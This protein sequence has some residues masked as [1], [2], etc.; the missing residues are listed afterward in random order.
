[1]KTYVAHPWIVANAA[2]TCLE[3]VMPGQT[4]QWVVLKD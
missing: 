2:G 3:I 1:M 4:T